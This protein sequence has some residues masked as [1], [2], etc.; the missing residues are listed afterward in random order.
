[1][2]TCIALAALACA[3]AAAGLWWWVD[4]GSGPD[5]DGLVAELADEA[6]V[7]GPHI[8]PA[9]ATWLN[10]DA[11]V[12]GVTVAGR[13]RGY[14]VRALHPPRRHVI[15][16][17]L[18]GV[19]VT[20][21]YCVR[22]D[23]AL[24]LTAA[25]P[26]EPLDVA[27]G[28][29]LGKLDFG[30]ML[31]RAG[32]WHYRMD[33]GLPWEGGA[34]SLPYARTAHERATWKAWREAYPDTDV[35]VGEPQAFPTGGGVSSNARR[36]VRATHPRAVPAGASRLGDE[37]DV[38]GV[39]VAGRHRAY[40]VRAFRQGTR[41]VI[42]D[43][44]AGF[45][46][47]VTFCGIAQCAQAFMGSRGDAPLG[48]SVS[49]FD[50]DYD[51]GGMVLRVGR[52]HYAHGTGL[53]MEQGAPAFPYARTDFERTTWKKWRDAHPDTDVYMDELSGA[54]ADLAH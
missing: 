44:V 18:G 50:G 39:S 51:W 27:F 31:V 29:Y 6:P 4:A 49:G 11:E 43:N 2:R 19:P 12:I 25:G 28:G 8:M 16:D 48:V 32:P 46:V 24:V 53:P 42:T 20:V 22:T 40:P 23:V 17:M 38:I 10:D 52:W 47:A 30:T 9:S 45:P 37:A 33:D 36:E 26:G 21:C 13:H 54:S 7:R 1:M 35:H 14:L 5:P 3:V 34:P 15:N 41:H